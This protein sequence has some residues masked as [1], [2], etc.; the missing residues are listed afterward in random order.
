MSRK[1][2]SFKDLKSVYGIP[3]C[4]T[5]LKRL[6][7]AGLFPKRVVLNQRTCRDTGRI[8]NT[9][10]AWWSD[11]VEAWL[12]ALARRNTEPDAPSREH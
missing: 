3:Y 9:R 12:D 8:I 2:T 6:E 1:L 5:H 7:D 11:E 10:V 4:N